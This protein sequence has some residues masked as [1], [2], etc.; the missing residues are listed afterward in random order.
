ML[1]DITLQTSAFN[2]ARIS[3]D[4]YSISNSFGI[5]NRWPSP[6]RTFSE[7]KAQRTATTEYIKS[8]ERWMADERWMAPRATRRI[9]SFT[10]T[11]RSL[12]MHGIHC[13][14]DEGS[15]RSSSFLPSQMVRSILSFILTR[16]FLDSPRIEIRIAPLLSSPLLHVDGSAESRGWLQTPQIRSV[17]LKRA[18]QRAR[19]H[20]GRHYALNWIEQEEPKGRNVVPP[21]IGAWTERVWLVW[22]LRRSDSWSCAAT[23]AGRP[24]GLALDHWQATHSTFHSI[25]SSTGEWDEGPPY[26]QHVST[27]FSKRISK[28]SKFSGLV[29]FCILCSHWDMLL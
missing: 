9:S 1:G 27:F 3:L 13:D 8:G 23:S 22:A 17:S 19:A 10:W 5:T 15:S 12:G 6:R 18:S 4:F 29:P 25:L 24:D 2:F 14:D 11:R 16:V 26:P 21:S 20:R 7:A 28:F